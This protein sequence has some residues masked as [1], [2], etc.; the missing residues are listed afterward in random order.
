MD[1]E[2]TISKFDKDDVENIGSS[3]EVYSNRRKEFSEK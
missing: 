3:N 2:D 1:P